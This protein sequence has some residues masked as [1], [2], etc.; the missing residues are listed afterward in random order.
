LV[1]GWEH[2][3]ALPDEK[4]DELVDESLLGE[5]MLVVFEQP[6]V[7]HEPRYNERSRCVLHNVAHVLEPALVDVVPPGELHL[8][9][10]AVV[11]WAQ[12]R[13]ASKLYSPQ[14]RWAYT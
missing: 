2:V 7:E 4:G 5:E 1:S 11:W 12:C 3:H 10:A 14:R 8:R 6:A 13:L 9:L